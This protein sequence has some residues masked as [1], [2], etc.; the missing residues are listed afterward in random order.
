MISTK[1]EAN[2][3]ENLQT[4][5]HEPQIWSA[6]RMSCDGGRHI[7]QMRS[8][9]RLSGNPE[10]SERRNK[11]RTTNTSLRPSESNMNLRSSESNP[12]QN[13]TDMEQSKEEPD[14]F[15]LIFFF[16]S[17]AVSE[18][19]FLSSHVD[20]PPPLSLVASTSIRRAS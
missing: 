4:E 14:Q 18:A 9:R 7:K 16:L 1:G 11:G 17:A 13:K 6:N 15:A 20:V 19:S 10:R 12:S 5:A 2:S 8:L 3:Y